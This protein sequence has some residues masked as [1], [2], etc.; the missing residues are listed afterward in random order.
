MKMASAANSRWHLKG[1]LTVI[2]ESV[3]S[4][5]ME[6]VNDSLRDPSYHPSP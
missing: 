1:L 3:L 2:F 4:H 6:R 5:E